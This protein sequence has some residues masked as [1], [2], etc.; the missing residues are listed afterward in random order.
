MEIFCLTEST[1]YGF[2]VCMDQMQKDVTL[3]PVIYTGCRV[4]QGSG[5]SAECGKVL[6]EERLLGLLSGVA[7]LQRHPACSQNAPL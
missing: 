1:K 6:V 4:L 3:R 7:N 2:G 5:V